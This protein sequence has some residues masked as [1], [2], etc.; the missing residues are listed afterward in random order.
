VTLTNE[1]DKVVVFERGELVYVFNFHPH[2]SYEHYL[3]GTNWPSPHM[4]LFE[5][6]EE[7]FGGHQRLNEGHGKWFKAEKQPWK[8]RPFSFKLYIPSRCAIVL[9]PFQFACKYKQV[10]LPPFEAED[11]DFKSFL[12]GSV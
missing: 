9:A 11:S 4:I 10:E 6:D 1:E 2:N 7:R 12:S 3:I 5:T 8:D